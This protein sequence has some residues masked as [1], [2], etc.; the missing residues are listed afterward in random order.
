MNITDF[1]IPQQEISLTNQVETIQV[2]SLFS[3]GI[4]QFDM[5]RTPPTNTRIKDIISAKGIFERNYVAYWVIETLPDKF[6]IMP[7]SFQESFK[8]NQKYFFIN[9]NILAPR[10]KLEIRLF[11]IWRM[12]AGTIKMGNKSFPQDPIRFPRIMPSR[13]KIFR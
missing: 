4:N 13:G 7:V 8:K 2:D 11:E 12:R 10:P 6:R 1:P 5:I 9:R 3:V